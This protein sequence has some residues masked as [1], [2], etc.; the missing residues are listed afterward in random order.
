MK[1]HLAEPAK[2]GK[3]FQQCTTRWQKN[4]YAHLTATVAQNSL[5]L[6]PCATIPII[7]NKEMHLF[8]PYQKVYFISFIKMHK[9]RLTTYNASRANKINVMYYT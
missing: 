2:L 5:K 4:V 8:Q 3:L 6:R 9:G 7:R 1:D